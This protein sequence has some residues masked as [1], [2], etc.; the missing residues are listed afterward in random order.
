MPTRS[1]FRRD[2]R[3]LLARIL[4]P[5]DRP[6]WLAAGLDR[7]MLEGNARGV[8]G[9]AAGT[10]LSLVAMAEVAGIGFALALLL[11]AGATLDRI[12]LS[13][14]LD[15]LPAGVRPARLLLARMLPG[16]VA[17]A[18][19]LGLFVSL[20]LASGDDMVVLTAG[21]AAVAGPVLYSA[22]YATHPRVFALATLLC[23]WPLPVV[24]L[25]TPEPDIALFCLLAMA[26]SGVAISAR[27]HKGRMSEARLAEAR[28]ARLLA[29]DLEQA[30]RGLAAAK[31]AAEEANRAKSRFL[32]AASHDLRQPVQSMML[33]AGVL[34]GQ[35]PAGPG[36]EALT[37]LGRGL[38]ELKSM[39][40]GLLDV[41]RLESGAVEPR[42]GTFDLGDLLAELAPSYD[43]VAQA[44]GIEFRVLGCGGPVRSDR[45]LLGRMLRNLLENAMRYTPAGGVVTLACHRAG[46]RLLVSVADTGLGIPADQLDLIFEEFHQ[47]GNPGR[48]RGEGLGLGLAIVRR[49]S[50]L[51]DCPV[52]VSSTLGRGSTFTL[53]VPIAEGAALPVPVPLVQAPAPRRRASGKLALVVDDDAIVLLGLK[54]MLEGLGFDVIVAADPDQAGDRVSRA[55][56]PP[57]LVV[58][59][60]RLRGGRTGTEAVARVRGLAGRPVPGLVLTGD[61]GPEVQ[62]EVES[63]GLGLVHKPVT[64]RQLA[65]ALE[66]VA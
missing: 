54:S 28:R 38:D 62:A 33:F 63:L 6:V 1:M 32:A 43:A 14:R 51:L 23:C 18:L 53:A 16:I 20:G 37:H 29:R 5:A 58:T 49:L 8:G 17:H 25:A 19:G 2:R 30:R 15:P 46:D 39:L 36:R 57:D 66:Q 35:V 64:P 9:M 27:R 45:M 47:V 12:L 52:R 3:P 10:V 59:D 22:R 42:L 44:R 40:D 31:E 34:E 24:G 55:A 48:N 21:A 65:R 11:Q 50:R 26:M 60:Y 41:S 7:L 13:R 61:V 4:H 56:K